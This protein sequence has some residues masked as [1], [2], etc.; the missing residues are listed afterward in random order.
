MSD[1]P[2]G[3]GKVAGSIPAG[4][5][6]KLLVKSTTYRLL[7]KL[8]TGT[9]RRHKTPESGSIRLQSVQN[10]CKP[11]QRF[12]SLAIRSLGQRSLH[13]HSS[14]PSMQGGAV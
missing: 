7:A 4:S 2:L 9:K 6:T 3:K 10:P 1:R 11:V 13:E 5:T 8:L 14:N 12:F